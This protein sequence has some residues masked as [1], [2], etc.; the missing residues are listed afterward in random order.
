[1]QLQKSQEYFDVKITGNNRGGCMAR[2]C[3]SGRAPA[4]KLRRSGAHAAL[5]PCRRGMSWA[6]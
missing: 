1:M 4:H 2:A 5:R 3:A 6:S